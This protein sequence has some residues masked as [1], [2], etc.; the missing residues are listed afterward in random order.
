MKVALKDGTRGEA[1]FSPC[2][3]YRYWL[4][5]VWDESKPT[6]AIIGMNPSTATE[7]DDDPTV[8]KETTII[9]SLGFGALLKLNAFAYRATLPVDLWKARQRGVDVIGPENTAP[10]IVE[11]LKLFAVKQTIAAWGKLK[12]DR[13]WFLSQSL[14]A[15]GIRLDCLKKNGDGSPAHPLYLPYG[16]IPEPWNYEQER[17]A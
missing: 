15:S 11:Y 7:K 5:R 2:G 17:T 13:G 8:A 16:L 12:T 9:R 1:Q 3:R 6:A 4:L 10:H 14:K